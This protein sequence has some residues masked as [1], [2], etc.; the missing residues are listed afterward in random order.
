[1]SHYSFLL[2]HLDCK[3]KPEKTA[4]ARNSGGSKNGLAARKTERLPQVLYLLFTR[5]AVYFY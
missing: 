5:Q 1:M 4:S 2:L 3:F